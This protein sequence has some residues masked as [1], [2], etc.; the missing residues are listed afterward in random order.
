M[1][2]LFL[3]TSCRLAKT[4]LIEDGKLL[5]EATDEG[6]KTH[7]SMLFPCIRRVLDDAGAEKDDIDVFSVTAG[8]GSYT[9]LRIS[10]SAAKTLSYSLGKPL[11]PVNT[12]RYL[13][14]SVSD[15]SD[16]RVSLIDGRNTL[17]YY[18]IAADEAFTPQDGLS[19]G[20]R[21]AIGTDSVGS[22]YVGN[23]CGALRE[24]CGGRQIVFTGDGANNYRDIIKDLYPKARFA[25]E[26]EIFGTYRGAFSETVKILNGQ[27]GAAL[28]AYNASVNYYKDV[29]VSLPR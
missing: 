14:A 3:D 9:G 22:D 25:P 24:C 12:L 1:K 21:S 28:D 8:P 13:L 29:H 19:S 17:C 4:Y 26:G 15:P 11:V 20:E 6:A 27:S 7:A 2:V 5:S 10:M 23:I 16:I 18:L